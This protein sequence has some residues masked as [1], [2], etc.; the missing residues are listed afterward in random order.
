MTVVLGCPDVYVLNLCAGE[1]D[2]E[3]MCVPGKRAE[4]RK[5]FFKVDSVK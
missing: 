5:Y 3:G 1:L 4:G 2:G